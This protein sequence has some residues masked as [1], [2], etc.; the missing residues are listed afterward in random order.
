MLALRFATRSLLQRPALFAASAS[1]PTVTC[2]TLKPVAVSSLTGWRGFNSQADQDDVRAKSAWPEAF[3]KPAIRQR[4]KNL[5]I[6]NLPLEATFGELQRLMAQ[7]GDITNITLTDTHGGSMRA[8]LHFRDADTADFAL[9][10]HKTQPF[11]IRGRELIIRSGETVNSPS[12][13]IYIGNVS[14][15]D[16]EEDIRELVR[17]F[18][19]PKT[20]RYSEHFATWT[21][22]V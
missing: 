20:I 10:A 6:E 9:H 19:E 11:T 22:A 2:L 7:F 5:S 15:E 4:F 3:S 12:C 21:H 18:F 1:R 14:F 17:P 16:T 13:T 8:V